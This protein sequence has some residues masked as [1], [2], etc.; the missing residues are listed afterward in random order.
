MARYKIK[1]IIKVETPFT[2][3]TKKI[4]CQGLNITRNV[5]G[6]YE[7]TL[8]CYWEMRKKTWTRNEY[9]PCSWTEVWTSKRHQIS[10]NQSV[11]IMFYQWEYQQ[12]GGEELNK[13][14]YPGKL[15]ELE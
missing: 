11:N 1:D 7:K 12:N 6:L 5:K 2:I 14:E 8:K 9:I 4:K 13:Q 10:L 15:W 3:A